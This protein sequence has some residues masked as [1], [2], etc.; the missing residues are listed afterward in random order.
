MVLSWILNSINLDIADS[1]IYAE[2][3]VEVWFHLKEIFSQNNAPRIF[4][5]QRDK[6]SH[7]QGTMS[8]TV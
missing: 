8:V 3:A 1:V 7:H 6:K 5:I 4:Q 2:S